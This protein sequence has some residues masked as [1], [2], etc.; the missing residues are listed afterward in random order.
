MFNN[1]PNDIIGQ[2]KTDQES[3]T[4]VF[5]A[6]KWKQLLLMMHRMIQE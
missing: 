2:K 3:P 5:V 6:N 1:F 4:S